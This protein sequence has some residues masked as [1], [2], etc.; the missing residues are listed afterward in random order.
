[1][2][3]RHATTSSQIGCVHT[4]CAAL[5]QKHPEAKDVLRVTLEQLAED[6]FAPSLKT[7]KLKGDLAG[8]W[9]CSAGYD[10]RIVFEFTKVDDVE[11]ILLH[12]IGTHDEV[13]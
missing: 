2:R 5:P 13:Y 10:V 12:S 6:V 9:S 1:M 11:G 8:F 7:H 3:S 4:L